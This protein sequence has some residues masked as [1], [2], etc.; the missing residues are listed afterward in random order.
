MKNF[1]NLNNSTET[2]EIGNYPQIE[3]FAKGY[4]YDSESSIFNIDKLETNTRFK[5]D[6]KDFILSRSS[7]LTDFLSF[8]SDFF[9]VSPKVIELLKKFEL[10]SHKLFD[11]IVRHGDKK[12]S[13]VI[14]YLFR[15]KYDYTDYSKSRFTLRF[16][17]K[18]SRENAIFKTKENFEKEVDQAHQRFTNII[19]FDSSQEISLDIFKVNKYQTGYFISEKLQKT[20]IDNKVTGIDYLENI[21][22]VFSPSLEKIILEKN[23]L[24]KL[25]FLTRR[26]FYSTGVLCRQ[27]NPETKAIEEFS[28]TGKKERELLLTRGDFRGSERMF[29]A[30]GNIKLEKIVKSNLE[31]TYRYYF[32]NGQ[33]NYE[34]THHDKSGV[35]CNKVYDID[36]KELKKYG[37]KNGTG[38]ILHYNSNGRGGEEL[39][40]RKHEL[41]R[42]NKF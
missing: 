24:A 19:Y 8:N 33:L 17:E 18:D 32:R 11:C 35:T 41:I 7:K 40:F 5:P 39:V 1:L 21:D 28:R 29:F 12:Y 36:G 6:L 22:T 26:S 15:N 20:F 30:N 9:L 31:V 2:S 37:L 3:G 13:Y 25:H 34:V 16:F 10:P 42:E 27:F 38:K 23:K 14:L 4:D